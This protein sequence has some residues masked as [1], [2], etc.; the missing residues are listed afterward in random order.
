[1]FTGLA[2]NS[3][4]M[5]DHPC[6]KVGGDSRMANSRTPRGTHERCRPMIGVVSQTCPEWG[7][8][9]KL[10][11]DG[12]NT[13]TQLAVDRVSSKPL[14]RPKNCLAP[15]PELL[16]ERAVAGEIFLL[17]IIEKATSLADDLE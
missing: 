5:Q 10:E 2:E 17:E 6:A 4:E 12:Y 15:Q 16:N 13:K 7:S 8:H 9:P 14:S 1:M 3:E 11:G